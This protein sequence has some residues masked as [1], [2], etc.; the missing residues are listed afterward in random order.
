MQPSDI[1]KKVKGYL[2]LIPSMTA[3]LEF[4]AVARLATF[5]LT[6]EELG[7]PQAAVSKQTH[8]HALGSSQPQNTPSLD[9]ERQYNV[10]DSRRI[11]GRA[12]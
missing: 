6:A 7:V 9:Q 1:D 10:Q 2:Q 8:F 3:L 12:P 5:T 4:K 11:L